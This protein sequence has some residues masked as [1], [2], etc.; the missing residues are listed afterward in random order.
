MSDRNFSR[1][2]GPQRF[3]PAGG[4]TPKVKPSTERDAT[5][6]RADATGNKLTEEQVFNRGRYQGEI[7]RS[8]NLAAGL[9]ADGEAHAHPDAS[10]SGTSR[11][12]EFREPNRATA[13]ESQ[14][15]PTF[16]P[17]KVPDKPH[18]IV[19]TLRNAAN[20][21]IHRVKKL[22]K[23]EKKVHKEVII[24]SESLETRVAVLEDGKLEEFTIERTEEERLVGSIFKGKIKNLEDGLKAAFVDIGFEK[25]AFLHY[26]DI[27][28]SSLDSGVEIV[29]REKKAPAKDA[30]PVKVP[31]KPKV[32]QKDIP[33]R[34]T[35]IAECKAEIAKLQP[36]LEPMRAKVKQ[37]T[38]QYF[39][40]LPK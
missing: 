28:P 27:V 10:A 26:W 2:R 19:E 7:D 5:E 25:N 13:D 8:E 32:T 40:M 31:E 39:T 36:Q 35:A 6:A 24:N 4:L 15:D 11:D 20:K 16:A 12:R 1:R 29:E 23:P 22:I 38:D 21:V 37:L 30:P 14:D 18:G 34:D 33:K 3:R 17:V 9:P